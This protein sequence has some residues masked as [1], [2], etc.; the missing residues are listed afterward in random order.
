MG[1]RNRDARPRGVQN[2][3]P[4]RPTHHARVG[5]LS[6]SGVLRPKF[7]LSS[8]CRQRCECDGDWR[9]VDWPGTWHRKLSLYKSRNWDWLRYCV[10]WTVVSW[11]G[12]LRG[13]YRTY[14]GKWSD[15]HLPLWQS[16][17]P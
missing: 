10:S 12:W 2:G 4:G 1:H 9:A 13:G 5:W 15:S 7:Y 11:G 8:L 6:R 17:L 3:S 16:R 14:P